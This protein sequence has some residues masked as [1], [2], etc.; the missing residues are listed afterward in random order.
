MTFLRV[1]AN[2]IRKDWLSNR[3]TIVWFVI[4]ICAP[5]FAPKRDDTEQMME[6]VV[7][8]AAF[9]YTYFV[10]TVERARRSLPLLLGLPIRPLHLV[11]A[12]YLSLY[13][14]CLITTNVG[15]AFL[16]DLR[17]L[18]LF[19]AEVLFLSTVFMAAIVICDHPL[20]PAIPLFLLA[21]AFQR[22][23]IQKA[24][25]PHLVPIA[26]VALILTPFIAIFSIVEFHRHSSA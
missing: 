9:G 14:M 4:G 8:A 5:L 3:K 12:K 2:I 17:L 24:M 6:V 10:F 15:G 21:L 25:T 1:A 16:H 13:S 18:Y 26:T 19:N 23:T 22:D 11:I 20:A 7:V